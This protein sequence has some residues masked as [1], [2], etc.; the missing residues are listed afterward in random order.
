MSLMKEP[1]PWDLRVF[2]ALQLPVLLR[3]LPDEA[4]SR[5]PPW[6]IIEEV[7]VSGAVTA[8]G[9]TLA[10]A[11]RLDLSRL[12]RIVFPIDGVCRTVFWRRLLL[13]PDS[14][15]LM[16][17]LRVRSA[18]P[19]LG[20]RQ[21]RL[22]RTAAR[23]AAPTI[24]SDNSDLHVRSGPRSSEFLNRAEEAPGDAEFIDFLRFNKKWWL[25]PDR[26]DAA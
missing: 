17:R 4:D 15:G 25:I 19:P 18:P 9:I 6:A 22:G 11:N 7:G 20:R 26:G 3:V 10:A 21:R 2:A 24:T 5:H 8:V 14:I 13:D 16:M 23:S 1:T 12:M